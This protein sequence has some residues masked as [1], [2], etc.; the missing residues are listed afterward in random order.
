MKGGNPTLFGAPSSVNRGLRAV[1]DGERY[2]CL[3]RDV[4]RDLWDQ[5][6][7]LQCETQAVIECDALILCQGADSDP[8]L[9][10]HVV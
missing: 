3:E 1:G 7:Y 10:S 6:E 8:Y 4:H 2:L 9:V 5:V